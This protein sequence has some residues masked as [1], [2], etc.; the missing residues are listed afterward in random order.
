VKNRRGAAVHGQSKFIPSAKDQPPDALL[1]IDQKVD[2][3]TMALLLKVYGAR[4]TL[5]QRAVGG[6]EGTRKPDGSVLWPFWGH[7]DPMCSF[8]HCA[9]GNTNLGSFSYQQAGDKP[10]ANSPAQADVIQLQVLRIQGLELLYQ[11]KKVGLELNV[12]QLAAGIDLANQSPSSACVQQPDKLLL[13]KLAAGIDPKGANTRTATDQF[14]SNTCRWGYIDRLL[15]ALTKRQL[16]GFDAV[17]YARQWSFFETDPASRRFNTWNASGFG[18]NPGI[19]QQDQRRRTFA[20]AAAIR[21]QIEHPE[22]FRN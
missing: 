10:V 5:V 7:R 14:S 2:A 21:Y 6:A 4:G 18:H 20:V 1:R 19:I 9:S 12:F 13:Y 15:Q 17:A 16:K 8:V 22:T 3:K 11:A